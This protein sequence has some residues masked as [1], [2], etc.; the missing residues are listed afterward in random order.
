ML[1]VKRSG[2]RSWVQCLTVHGE[3]I[4]LGLGSADP[5]SAEYVSLAQ[6][7]RVALDN[8]REAR[9][10]ADRRGRSHGLDEPR[11]RPY[12]ADARVGAHRGLL[13]RSGAMLASATRAT[14]V[15]G[16]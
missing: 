13:H 10:G 12:L 14:N 15:S 7:R 5:D 4:D 9:A 3:R 16:P 2:A 1:Y 6:A 8:R 11:G